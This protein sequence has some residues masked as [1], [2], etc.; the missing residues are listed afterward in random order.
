MHSRV[1]ESHDAHG[2]QHLHREPGGGRL[3]CHPVLSAGDSA[4]GRDRDLVHG[5]I[6]VQGTHLF[7]GECGGERRGWRRKV[8]V[9]TILLDCPSFSRRDNHRIG[10]SCSPY[11][12]LIILLFSSVFLLFTTNVICLLEVGGGSQRRTKLV[13]PQCHSSPVLLHQSIN[14]LTVGSKVLT[15]L[16]TINSPALIIK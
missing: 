5:Q 11:Y 9:Q 12:D 13:S 10:T 15:M 8:A 14:T 6:N 4:V 2:D 1:H 3:L 7:P 16:L